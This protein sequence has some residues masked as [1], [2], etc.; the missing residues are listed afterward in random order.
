MYID[1]MNN[2]LCEFVYSL[3]YSITSLVWNIR[4]SFQLRRRKRT[5]DRKKEQ[6]MNEIVEIARIE[7]YKIV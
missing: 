5:N 1:R 6:E 3:T 7:G 2:F 4:I